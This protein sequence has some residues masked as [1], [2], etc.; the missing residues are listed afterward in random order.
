MSE[1]SENTRDP[2][3]FCVVIKKRAFGL[4]EPQ[5]VA[6]YKDRPNDIDDAYR[7]TLKLLQYYNCQAVLESSKISILT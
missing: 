3:E 2:S 1:T 6:Y 7:N 5:Y 4:Q